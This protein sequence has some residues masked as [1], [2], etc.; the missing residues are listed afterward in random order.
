[1]DKPWSEKVSEKT[2]K[3][4]WDTLQYLQEW[5]DSKIWLQPQF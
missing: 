2:I 5:K 4:V 1:M 3:V